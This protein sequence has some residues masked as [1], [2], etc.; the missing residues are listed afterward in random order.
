M[1]STTL[2]LISGAILLIA[3]VV[4]GVL[5]STRRAA[6]KR[7][8]DTPSLGNDP[9]GRPS[10]P[11]LD[12]GD[13]QGSSVDTLDERELSGEPSLT[14]RV[15]IEPEPELDRPEAPES[16]LAR[17]RRRLAGSTSVLSRGLLLLLTRDRIDEETWDDF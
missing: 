11:A 9:S 14:D 4:V 6:L 17:L 13:T 12:A 2:F 5:A 7:G 16:R 1:Q 3:F 15:R 8:A 10:A